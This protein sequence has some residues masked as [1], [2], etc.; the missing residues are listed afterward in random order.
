MIR[1]EEGIHLILKKGD[2]F[3]IEIKSVPTPFFTEEIQNTSKGYKLKLEGLN[4]EKDALIYSGKKFWL[5]PENI[6][7][8]KSFL[9]ELENFEVHDANSGL[10]G[11][12]VRIEGNKMNPLL[13]ILHLNKEILLPYQESFIEKIDHKTKKIHYCAPEGLLDIYLSDENE[14]ND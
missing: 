8:K 1:T 10:I 2:P 11:S 7:K 3:F 13:C 5:K 14:K 6:E 4:N 9:S 12:V